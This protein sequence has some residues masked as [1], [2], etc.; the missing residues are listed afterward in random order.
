MLAL[1][2]YQGPVLE[3][4]LL[5]CGMGDLILGRVSRL[6]AFSAYLLRTWLPSLYPWQDS[7]YTIGTLIPVL[8][9]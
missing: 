9:Y 5:P 7:W 6:D 3:P 2:A 1:P 4:L 8:S